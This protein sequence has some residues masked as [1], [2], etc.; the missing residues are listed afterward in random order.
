MKKLLILLFTIQSIHI[1]SLEQPLPLFFLQEEEIPFFFFQ[2]DDDDSDEEEILPN[3]NN[4]AGNVAVFFVYNHY[5]ENLDPEDP[6]N[7]NQHI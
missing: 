5:V 1:C 2:N 6:A 7:I 4:F 3:I